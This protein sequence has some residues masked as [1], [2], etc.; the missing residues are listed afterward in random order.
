MK[1]KLS[2]ILLVLIA[3]MSV[4]K[5]MAWGT[6][7]HHITAYIAEKHLTPQAKEKCEHYL[8]HS[9][10]HYSS[11]Q[12]YWRHSKPFNEIHHWHMNYV[13]TNLRTIGSK[14]DVTRD[15][16][17][18]LNRIIGEMEKGKYHNM[19]DS[20]V[21]V[22]LKLLIHMVGDMHC[23]CHVGYPKE[24]GLKGTSMYVKGKKYDRHKFWDASPELMHPKWRLDNYLKA[25]DT[26]SPKEIKKIQ[27]GNPTKWGLENA[28]KMQAT[29]TYWEKK[30][31]LTKISKEQRKQ[32]ND[33]M[34]EQLVYGGYRLAGVL[35][36][37]FSK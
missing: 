34:Y 20:M 17:T 29:Y 6:W 3:T 8:K 19:S 26:Y 18:Q 16:V 22:N 24:L 10:P 9:L 4:Q 27:K 35:N 31:E 11:W 28:K 37:I 23:P 1:N 21:I 36:S 33:T 15:A 5:A 30:A 2:I 14:G 12:D 32:I 7:G 25:C 13:G